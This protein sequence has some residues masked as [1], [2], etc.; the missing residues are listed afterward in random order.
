MAEV[1]YVPVV[2]QTQDFPDELLAAGVAASSNASNRPPTPEGKI[3]IREHF[4][5]QSGSHEETS[6][7]PAPDAEGPQE[8]SHGSN[9]LNPEEEISREHYKTDAVRDAFMA[10]NRAPSRKLREKQ[11]KDIL[12]PSDRGLWDSLIAAYY[13][14]ITEWKGRSGRDIDSH[15][16]C[17]GRYKLLDVKRPSLEVFVKERI[18]AARPL[19]TRRDVR[20]KDVDKIVW[21]DFDEDGLALSEK[22]DVVAILKTGQNRGYFTANERAE[23]SF[24]ISQLDSI[25]W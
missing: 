17:R 7:P 25:R 11:L 2:S 10:A 14:D 23:Y 19:V 20:R 18:D 12:L 3:R 9:D 15:Y 21:Q 5:R 22:K 1:E 13:H 24:Y 16:D 8:T 4:R 6:N